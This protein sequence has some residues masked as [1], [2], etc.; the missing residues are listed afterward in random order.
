M[1]ILKATYLD[2]VLR[3]GMDTSPTSQ[4]HDSNKLSHVFG[5]ALINFGLGRNGFLPL[6]P[7]K[8][9]YIVQM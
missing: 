7:P 4:T 9:P 1:N 3:T 2:Y 8:T 6:G 5:Y